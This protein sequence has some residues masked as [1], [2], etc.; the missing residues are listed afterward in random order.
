[1]S[2]GVRYSVSVGLDGQVVVLGVSGSDSTDISLRM[3]VDCA[4]RFAGAVIDK[5]IEARRASEP[6]VVGSDEDVPSWG[7][8]DHGMS[9]E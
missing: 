3:D 8:H 9:S 2:D 5:C 6:E 7:G 4:Y 1:M